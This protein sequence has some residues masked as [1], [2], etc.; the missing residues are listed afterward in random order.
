[1]NNMKAF[2]SLKLHKFPVELKT[3]YHTYPLMFSGPGGAIGFVYV[4][5]SKE[6]ALK[7]EG[8]NTEL[9]QIEIYSEDN[10]EK[11]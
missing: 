7:E 3:D 5:A 2:L 1:M 4:F 8:S 10:N 6:E 11:Q 9:L